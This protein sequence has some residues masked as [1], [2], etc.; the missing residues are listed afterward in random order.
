MQIDD[1]IRQVEADAPDKEPLTLLRTAS[2]MVQS[3]TDA[4]DA[5]LGYFV[6]QARRAGHSWTDIGACLGVSKQAAQQRHVRVAADLQTQLFGRA[7]DRARRV[8]TATEEVARDLGHA[9]VGTEHVLLAQFAEPKSVAAR[10][11]K[12]EGLSAKSVR[13]A[14]VELTGEGEGAPDGAI[15][16]TPRAME[17]FRDALAIALQLGHNYIGTEHRLLAMFRGE[18]LAGRILSDA[19]LDEEA[20]RDEVVAE[21]ARIVKQ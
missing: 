20:M 17:L 16:F 12:K 19:G 14:I 5:A 10:L 4:A 1:L 8:V 6:D 18:G 3:V 2:S 21:L 9:Y 15:P 7:T 13:A 11:L